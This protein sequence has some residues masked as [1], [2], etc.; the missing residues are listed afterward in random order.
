MKLS[1]FWYFPP[2]LFT[3]IS[4]FCPFDFD[5]LRDGLILW[6]FV[7]FPDLVDTL[8]VQKRQGR[9]LLHIFNISRLYF[10]KSIIQITNFSHYQRNAKIHW[11][12]NGG[13]WQT[14]YKK[15]NKKCLYIDPQ[16]KGGSKIRILAIMKGM[17]RL[18][19][20]QDFIKELKWK[21]KYFLQT[22]S[23]THIELKIPEGM[24]FKN[25]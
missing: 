21:W 18:Q 7:D 13:H 15:W 4:W 24:L 25:L 3:N 6:L 8:S 11:N 9:I 16:Y 19:M 12:L 17:G 14:S 10:N 5:F 1:R 2:W 22:S 23:P 20:L